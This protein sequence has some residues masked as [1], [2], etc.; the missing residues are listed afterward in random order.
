M[1]IKYGFEEEVYEIDDP[2]LNMDKNAYKNYVE[3]KIVFENKAPIEKW[4]EMAEEEFFLKM[5]KTTDP[6]VKL[7]VHKIK[8]DLAV[9]ESILTL[10][11]AIKDYPW[12]NIIASNPNLFYDEKTPSTGLGQ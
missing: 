9:L 5:A 4:K 7:I 12:I 11:S 10:P 8:P 2:F 1:L 6:A 3:E